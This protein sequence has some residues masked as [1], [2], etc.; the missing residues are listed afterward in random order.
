MSRVALASGPT[1]ASVSNHRSRADPGRSTAP[2][3]RVADLRIR[4]NHRVREDQHSMAKPSRSTDDRHRADLNSLLQ[5][6][7]GLHDGTVAN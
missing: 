3:L 4:A 7:T 6:C 5:V 2:R 1:M